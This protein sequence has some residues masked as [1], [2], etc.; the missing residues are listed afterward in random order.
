VQVCVVF[1]DGLDTSD[2]R[3]QV[4]KSARVSIILIRWCIVGARMA[5]Y[6]AGI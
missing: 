2:I 3:M 5:K 1:A 6:M 4:I